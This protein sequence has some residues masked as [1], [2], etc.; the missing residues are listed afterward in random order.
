MSGR[1]P[2]RLL[3]LIILSLAL[4]LFASGTPTQT[5]APALTPASILNEMQRVADWQLAHPV[6]ERPTGWICGVGDIGMMALAGISSDPK[7][8]D[9]MLAKGNAQDW[10][11]PEYQGRKY[12]A[13]DQCIGQVW[14]ELYFRYRDKK[15]IAPMRAKM[16]FILAN[17]P[18]DQSLETVPGKAQETWSWC[19]AL[20]MAPPAWMRLYAATGDERYLNY[21]V[22]NFWRTADFLYDKDEHLFFRDSTFF[23]KSE[24]NGTKVFWSRGNGWVFAGI[25]R[26]LE[27]LPQGNPNRRRFEQLFRDMATKILVCQQPDGS[28]HASLLDSAD[29]PMPEASGTAL[30]TY[31]LAWGINQGLLDRAACEPAVRKAWSALVNCVDDSGKITRVQPHGAEPVQFPE[32][33]TAPYGAGVFLLAGSEVYRMAHLENDP[34]LIDQRQKRQ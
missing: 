12:H 11:L 16:D 6:T 21:A 8:R 32:D 7:Y 23:Q 10:Q 18:T 15:M 17:P 22:S 30:F 9:A 13:D 25:V 27:Y 4:P 20:F 33:S 29:Y 3:A 31:G 24:A 2:G 28:W 1:L 34:S 14:S 19:D 5:A 26:I